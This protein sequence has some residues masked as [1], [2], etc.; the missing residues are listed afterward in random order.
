MNPERA[1][2]QV[3]V[4]RPIAV[5][6]PELAPAGPERPA[7]E[8]P[9]APAIDI[10]EG[11]EGLVLEADLPGVDEG[12]LTIEIVHNVLSLRAL[13][14]PRNACGLRPLHEESRPGEFQRSFILSDEV[15]R[16]AISAEMRNGV[17][18]LVLP[19]AERS[20]ARRIE[21]KAP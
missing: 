21:V 19:R 17:L 2:I 6:A 15:D 18:R 12:G 16:D 10:H 9:L 20:K 3:T 5:A 13:P 14:N 11:P 1:A 7:A 4:G 8:M